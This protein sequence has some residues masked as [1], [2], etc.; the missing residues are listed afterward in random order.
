MKQFIALSLVGFLIL[1]FG[2]T[3]YAQAPKLEFKAS[4]FIDTQT[5]LGEN[6]PQYNNNPGNTDIWGVV[7]R[8][9]ARTTPSGTYGI[10]S[11]GWNKTDAHWEGRAH[12]KFDAIMGPNLSGTIYFEIDTYRWGAPFQGYPGIGREANNF[13]AWTTDRTAI[14]VKNIYINF[15]LPYFGIPVPI[16]VRVG[17]QPLGVRPNMLMYTDGTGVTAGI[18]ID[19]VMIIP[20]YAKALEGKDFADDDVDVW[21]L[22]ANAKI[23]TF[24][25]GGYGLYYRMNTYPLYVTSTIAGLPAALIPAVPGTNKSHMWWFGIYADGKAGPVNLNFDFVYDYGTVNERNTLNI[26]DVK[27]QGWATRLKVDYPWEK[28]NFGAVGMYASGADTRKTSSSGLPGSTTNIGTVSKSVRGY[29]IPP[30][31]EQSTADQE[32]IVVYSM[33]S[34]ATG[35]Y[36]IA[37]MINYAQVSRGG[38]GGTWFA[39]L[40]GSVMLAPWYKVT[41]QGLYVGDTTTHGNTL[42]NAV[43]YNNSSRLRDDNSI[44]FELDLMNDIQIYNNLRFWVGVGYLWAGNALDINNGGTGLNRAAA[45]PWALRTRLIYTF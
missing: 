4:G 44:G 1:A 3:A 5:F 34:G 12:L 21:G 36:G 11:Q 40:Y 37:H 14:E 33:E 30:G 18:K 15:G 19:P 29:V 27:Y 25:V 41:L 17:A 23:S 42:G 28:F 45:N 9:Y 13:G 31:A 20:I 2:A 6:V 7:N 43:K 26:P 32:S 35:G 38:F 24:T 22:H 8:N 16:T 39:K 10:G